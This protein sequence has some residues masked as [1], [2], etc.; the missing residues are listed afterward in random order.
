MAS[1]DAQAIFAASD[2]ASEVVD[3]PEWGRKIEIR[4]L[5]GRQRDSV[6]TLAVEGK[7]NVGHFVVFGAFNPE[8]GARIFDDSDLD[9][10]LQKSGRV[11]ARLAVRIRNMSGLNLFAAHEADEG[12]GESGTPDGESSSGAPPETSG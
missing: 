7:L 10:L 4:E 12:K 3:V 8:T 1:G 9:H 6:E 5:T 11:L 2:I